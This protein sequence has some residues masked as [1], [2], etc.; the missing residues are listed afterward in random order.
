MFKPSYTTHGVTLMRNQLADTLNALL[1]TSPSD[2]YTL[3]LLQVAMAN[4]IIYEAPGSVV[5]RRV[6]AITAHVRSTAQG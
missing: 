6:P 4:G 3:A 5:T 1:I 2:D